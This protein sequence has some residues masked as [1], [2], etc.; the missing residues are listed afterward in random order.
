MG[1]LDQLMDLMPFKNQLPVQNLTP[2]ESHLRTAKAIIHSMTL[3][4]RKNPRLL[5]RKSKTSHF[6]RQWNNSK[7]NKHA[8]FAVADDES[9]AEPAG[10][11]GDA[12]DGTEGGSATGVETEDIQ[13][14][15]KTE[16]PQITIGRLQKGRLLC[17]QH[18]YQG[19]IFWQLELDYNDTVERNVLFIGWWRQTHAPKGTVCFWNASVITIL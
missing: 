7:S 14:T 2:D 1:P 9:Y 3:E 13:E 18:K 10:G 16:T 8:G 6:Q 15:S 5:D 19:G 4:E 11:D 17:K 12:T